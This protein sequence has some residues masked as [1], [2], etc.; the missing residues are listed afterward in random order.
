LQIST[1]KLRAAASFNSSVV[2]GL[3]T[4]HNAKVWH[5]HSPSQGVLVPISKE[6][7]IAD[8]ETMRQVLAFAAGAFGS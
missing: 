5:W 2:Q 6:I 7:R 8:K 3:H 4:A 1:A